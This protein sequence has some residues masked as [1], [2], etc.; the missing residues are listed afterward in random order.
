[1][2]FKNY[3]PHVIRI[4]DETGERTAFGSLGLARVA[5]SQTRVESPGKFR[6]MRNEYG[7]VEGLP[8][9]QEGVVYVVSG[10]VLDRAKAEG[11]TDCVAPDTGRDVIRDEKGQIEAV[12]GF[13]C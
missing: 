13:V 10:L 9:P 1:M 11:R 7:Q 2:E 6:M 3:T 12:R 4:E 8:E 5:V